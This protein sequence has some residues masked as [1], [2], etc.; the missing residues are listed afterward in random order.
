MNKGDRA[1]ICGDDYT[2]IDV[3]LHSHKG[4][5]VT[6]ISEVTPDEAC[7]YPKYRDGHKASID[8][9]GTSPYWFPARTLEPIETRRTQKE[10]KTMIVQV[11]ILKK[12]TIEA[13]EKG[14]T[15]EIIV[16]VT[17]VV[18]S[19]VDSGIAIV[20]AKNAA[21]IA[22]MKGPEIRVIASPVANS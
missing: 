14:A 7:S 19:D 12:P 4:K 15:E 11:R 1:R 13:Q 9:L 2:L 10:T 8:G 20:A 3:G 17:E 16:P 21:A 22:G 6:I 18:A 5:M